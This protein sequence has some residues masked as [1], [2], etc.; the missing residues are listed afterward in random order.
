[1][2]EMAELIPGSNGVFDV[3]ADGKLLF[4]KKTAGRFPESDEVLNALDA[5]KS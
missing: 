1:M 4:S 5:L 3:V 2:G